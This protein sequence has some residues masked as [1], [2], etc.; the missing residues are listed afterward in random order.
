[1]LTSVGEG[2]DPPEA[3]IKRLD[4]SDHFPIRATRSSIRGE[5]WWGAIVM[6][7]LKTV[8]DIMGGSSKAG[9]FL[10]TNLDPINI[11]YHAARVY[12]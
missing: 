7:F 2:G 11:F 9:K 6:W 12:N 8:S 3:E 1:M 10:A 4:S 5:G